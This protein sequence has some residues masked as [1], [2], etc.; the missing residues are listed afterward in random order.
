M[1]NWTC[2]TPHTA[3]IFVVGGNLLSDSVELHREEALSLFGRVAR[4]PVAPRAQVLPLGQEFRIESFS[5]REDSGVVIQ[6]LYVV[7]SSSPPL[8]GT[9]KH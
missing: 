4:W 7:A 6:Y 2:K 9:T 5:D 3:K 1:L 8:P